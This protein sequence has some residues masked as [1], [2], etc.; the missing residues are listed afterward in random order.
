[1]NK[2]KTAAGYTSAQ[3]ELAKSAVLTLATYLGPFQNELVV[4]GGLVPSFI[5]ESPSE[6]HVGTAD[7]DIGPPWTDAGG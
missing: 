1:M 5:V 7:V 6:P 2:P 3:F 4:V